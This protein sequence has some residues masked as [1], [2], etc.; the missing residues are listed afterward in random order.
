MGKR[1]F[2]ILF[3]CLL[4]LTS[5]IGN[6]SAAEQYVDDV[7]VIHYEDG[8]YLTISTFEV[9]SRSTNTKSGCRE[10]IYTDSSGVE[11]W[12]CVLNATFTYDGTTSRATLAS[13]DFTSS[14]SN[15]VKD[16]LFTYRSSNTAYADL[17]V[18]QK[19]LGITVDTYKYT[20]SLSCDK[21]GNL[22]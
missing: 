20:F 17:T 4:C 8:S 9:S 22:S 16:T 19:F 13:A 21:D 7:I 12:R 11:Q 18:I 10:Y 5:I 14:S 3:A 6:A 1:F 2:V 15:W